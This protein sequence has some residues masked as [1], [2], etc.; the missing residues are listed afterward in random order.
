[1]PDVYVSIT[2]RPLTQWPTNR[3]FTAH[4]LRED[5]NFARGEW[6]QN[7]AGDPNSGAKFTKTRTP[8]SRTLKELD[9]ELSM[10]GARAVVCQIDISE[11]QLRLDGDLRSDA[12][13]KSPPVVLTFTRKDVPY[14]FACDRFKR[15]QDN[16]RA[17]VLG[18]EGLRRLE[19][20]H[21][22]Q[23]GD[24]YRGWQ[25]LPAS[26]T[27]AFNVD[28]AALFLDKWGGYGDDVIKRDISVAR[29]AYR[30]AASRTHPDAGGSTGNFQLTQEAK[31]VLEAHFG[32]TL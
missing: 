11:R 19:R 26:T 28:Q 20:Y 2:W 13:A 15:W 32:G 16:L 17:I 18:L 23:S 24:Q 5:A 3:P 8:L 29:N 7:V 31:R 9:R 1:V 25:A 27:T 10:I 14:V 6:K 4:W 12:T 30:V 21:I 22:A